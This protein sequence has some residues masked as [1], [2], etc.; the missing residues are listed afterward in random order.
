MGWLAMAFKSLIWQG[1]RITLDLDK[2]QNQSIAYSLK[3]I[4]WIAKELKE[5]PDDKGGLAYLSRQLSL[6]SMEIDC[7]LALCCT[8]KAEKAEPV[9]YPEGVDNV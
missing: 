8:G 5:K 9:K 3:K 2:T 6:A 4:E 1:M 7:A